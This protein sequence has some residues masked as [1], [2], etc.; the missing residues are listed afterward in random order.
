MNLAASLSIARLG[1]SATAEQTT[2]TSRNVANVGKPMAARKMGQL[3]NVVGGGVRVAVIARS[4]NEALS[5]THLDAV[6]QASRQDTVVRLLD[7][8]DATVGDPEN[9]SSPAGLMSKLS[10]A[11][12]GY[13]AAPTDIAAGRAAV[14]AAEDLARGLNTAT[15]TVQDVRRQADDGIASAVT[16]LRDLLQ[17]FG[18]LNTEVVNGTRLGSDITDQLDQRDEVVSSIAELVGV[19][20]VMRADGDMALYTDGG[21]TLFETSARNISFSTTLNLAPGINGTAV[22]IDGVPVTGPS[23]V[24]ASHSGSIAGLATVR[25][26]AA[27]TF[28]RQI[29]EIARGLIET[30]AEKDPAA[31][32]TLPDAAGL[33]TWSGGPTV[34]PAGTLVDGISATIAVNPAVDPAQ[35][36]T[37]SKLRDGGIAGAGYVVNTAGSAG[38]TAHLVAFQDAL[39]TPRTFDTSAAVGSNI[40]LTAYAANSIS[41]LSAERQTA[42]NA[43]EYRASV[44]TRATSALS[45]ATGISLD[46]EMANMLD[47]ERSYQ[48]TSKLIATIDQ[49]LQ[50]LMSAIR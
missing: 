39:S 21:V 41:W 34:P 36:G 2:V 43:S 49:M 3:S 20:R 18:K 29:D 13:A 8:L 14:A 42:T 19:R 25:D 23:A 17:R 27:V 35:G 22:V 6:A 31:V 28:Q 9:D 24:M 32:P 11:L 5:A 40:A 16:S 50:D 38:Y 15:A 1:L 26:G 47:L 48:A 4:A 12:Q 45:N 7:Q 44:L 30:F 33:F 37:P 10:S 46:D